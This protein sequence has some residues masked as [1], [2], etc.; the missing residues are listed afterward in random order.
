MIPMCP[1]YSYNGYQLLHAF[2]SILTLPIIFKLIQDVLLFVVI[3][4]Y[5]ALKDKN[6]FKN[7]AMIPSSHQKKTNKPLI[8]IKYEASVHIPPTNRL[9]LNSQLVEC[10][11][12]HTLQF[13]IFLNSLSF[14]GNMKIQY[15]QRS[16]QI[17]KCTTW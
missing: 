1:P 12:H 10:K 6:S 7:L 5:V 2:L 8:I 11:I 16:S 15:I 17:L 14:L 3:L 13:D 4:Q 9:F